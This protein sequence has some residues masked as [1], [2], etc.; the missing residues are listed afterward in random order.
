MSKPEDD[1]IYSRKEV[2]ETLQIC[3]AT[4]A[5]YCFMLN[6]EPRMKK[7]TAEQL[8]LMKNMRNHTEKGGTKYD[9]I[10]SLVHTQAA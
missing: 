4:L 9:F 8:Q 10:Q 1:R 7:I 2:I 3:R 6:I 5:T